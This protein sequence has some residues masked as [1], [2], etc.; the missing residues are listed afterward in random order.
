[1]G[2]SS[3]LPAPVKTLRAT[4][5]LNLLSEGAVMTVKKIVTPDAGKAGQL[6]KKPELMKERL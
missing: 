5:H 6:D 1:M 2:K 4:S 3:S